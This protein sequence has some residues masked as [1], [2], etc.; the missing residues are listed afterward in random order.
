MKE[1][2]LLSFKKHYYFQ[3]S[4]DYND[5]QLEIDG[6]RWKSDP[7]FLMWI[8]CQI[9]RLMDSGHPVLMGF[10]SNEFSDAMR[11][12]LAEIQANSEADQVDGDDPLYDS[13]FQQDSGRMEVKNPAPVIA[14]TAAGETL[15]L[16][17]Y[18]DSDSDEEVTPPNDPTLDEVFQQIRCCVDLETLQFFI[19]SGAWVGNPA[20]QKAIQSRYY[21]LDSDGRFKFQFACEE[22]W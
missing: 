13:E 11:N 18:S 2:L 22:F 4:I 19:L 6:G 1:I 20:V 16:V 3:D 10:G 21:E 7:A 5:L 15:R 14:G 9:K 12:R 17:D 8:V